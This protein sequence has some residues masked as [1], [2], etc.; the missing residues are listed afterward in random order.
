MPGRVTV[1]LVGQGHVANGLAPD[2]VEE[3]LTAVPV[4]PVYGPIVVNWVIVLLRN[5]VSKRVPH[6]LVRFVA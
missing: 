4:V 3:I 6:W 2:E 5:V 1:V